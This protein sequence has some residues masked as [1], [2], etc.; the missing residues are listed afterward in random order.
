MARVR[1]KTTTTRSP[2]EAPPPRLLSRRLILAC[3]GTL[4]LGMVGGAAL[5]RLGR[6]TGAGRLT[7]GDGPGK[8]VPLSAPDPARVRVV[9]GEDLASV[10]K[11]FLD[12]AELASR[13]PLTAREFLAEGAEPSIFDPPRFGPTQVIRPEE[14][15]TRAPISQPAPTPLAAPSQA[16]ERSVAAL[17]QPKPHAAAWLE[18]GLSVTD[19]GGRPMIAVVIDDLGLNRVTTQAIIG[20]PGP[21][22]LSH[23]AYAKSP[24]G[25]VSASRAFGHETMLH[26]PMEPM[27][28]RQD[29]GPGALMARHTADEI[30]TRMIAALDRFP[31]V[32]GVNNHMGSR[33]TSDSRGMGVLME[34]LADRGL[35]FLDSRTTGRS[36]APA[37]ARAHGVP[38][39]ERAVFIDHEDDPMVIRTQ[40]ALTERV[41]ARHGHAVAIGHP[42]QNTHEALAR[43]LPKLAASGYALVP[44]SA[45]IRY[46]V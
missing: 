4:A 40:L 2:L 27:D 20:L 22:T 36:V 39:T 28:S 1:S 13:E 23:M 8:A 44:A 24:D 18:N 32:V 11:T 46:H 10:R 7:L 14:V 33:F 29:P 5:A 15:A 21:L 17:P 41:A 12:P 35:M 37:L 38:F 45:I 30:R 26:L 25:L 6:A 34:N 42:R 16:L 9:D 43:W 31:G 3:A 19:P